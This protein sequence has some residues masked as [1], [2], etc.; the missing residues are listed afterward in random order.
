MRL[1]IK[2]LVAAIVGGD[3][4]I[5]S[6]AASDLAMIL[7]AQRYDTFAEY[8]P[9]DVAREKLSLQEE[10]ELA[11][12]IEEAM[13]GVSN[14]LRR[15][16]FFCLGQLGPVASLLPL[17]RCCSR[18]ASQLDDWGAGNA[19]I[20]LDCCMSRCESAFLAEN[21]DVFRRFPLTSFLQRC[22][23][24]EIECRCSSPSRIHDMLNHILQLEK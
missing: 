21:E 18:F 20:S 16:L 14:D 23:V 6:D 17:V 4:M 2:E 22:R 13:A 8:L 1:T 24:P 9:E 11:H 7:D 5:A 12:A 10:V 19:V 3:A 15:Q